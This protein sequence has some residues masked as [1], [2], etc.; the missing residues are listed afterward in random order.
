MAKSPEIS[1]KG[2]GDAELQLV[3]FKIQTEDLVLR[4]TV[5]RR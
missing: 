4:S 3:V 5:C 2:S 1:D